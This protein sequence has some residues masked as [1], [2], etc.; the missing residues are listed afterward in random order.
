MQST[1]LRL[2]LVLTRIVKDFSFVMVMSACH[3]IA[4]FLLIVFY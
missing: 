3:I 4:V 1:T 2:P